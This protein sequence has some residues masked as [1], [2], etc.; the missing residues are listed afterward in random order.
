MFGRAAELNE[1][2]HFKDVVVRVRS[3]T[4]GPCAERIPDYQGASTLGCNAGL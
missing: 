4:G 3:E 1:L 2:K